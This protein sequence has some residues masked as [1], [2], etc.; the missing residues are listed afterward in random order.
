MYKLC[1]F[2]P[3]SHLEQVKDAIFV[4]GAGRV[5]GY[6]QY[7]W[8]CEGVTQFRPLA[9]SQP[10]CGE[11]G[12]L[13]AVPEVKVETVVEDHCLSAVIEALRATHP[14]EQPALEAWPITIV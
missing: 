1:F 12:R 10:H 9:G 13:E 7:C 14:Y 4:A 8:Q 2:V 11:T 5:G 6:D 3:D